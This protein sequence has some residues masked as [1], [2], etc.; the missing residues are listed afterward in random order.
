[1]AKRRKKAPKRRHYMRRGSRIP[2]DLAEHLADVVRNKTNGTPAGL[3][4]YAEANPGDPTY[5]M[6]E[7]NDTVAAKK[8]RLHEARQIIL[9]IQV[10]DLSEEDKAP[11]DRDTVS[12][13]YCIKDEDQSR[14][15]HYDVVSHNKEMAA[16]V[17]SRARRDLAVFERRYRKYEEHFG[18]LLKDIREFVNA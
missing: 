6:F 11:A 3:L 18:H 12:A 14:Y 5:E 8:W 7:W 13:F 10:G 9:S 2:D 1:M 4:E 17:V 16:S 15:E